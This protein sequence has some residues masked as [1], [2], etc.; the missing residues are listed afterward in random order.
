MVKVLVRPS[1]I[2]FFHGCRWR[3]GEI[4]D[5]PESQC[6]DKKAPQWGVFAGTAE[7]KALTEQ[8][9]ARSDERKA[10]TYAPSSLVQKGA[11]IAE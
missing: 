11:P 8:I 5:V 4:V 7:A 3:E 2:A 6:P 9:K 10:K 1:Q